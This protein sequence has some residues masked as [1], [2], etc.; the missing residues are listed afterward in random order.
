[1]YIKDTPLQCWRP[2]YK[3]TEQIERDALQTGGTFFIVLGTPPLFIV[4]ARQKL[5]MAI[6]LRMP[7]FSSFFRVGT[8]IAQE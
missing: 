5:G 7:F 4:F 3:I 8:L 6:V 1:V 2:V